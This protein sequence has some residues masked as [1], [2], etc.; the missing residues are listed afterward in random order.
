M[1]TRIGLFDETD[2]CRGRQP[3]EE[4]NLRTP[5][6]ERLL[7]KRVSENLEEIGNLQR[8][9]CENFAVSWIKRSYQMVRLSRGC[10]HDIRPGPRATRLSGLQGKR[11][12]EPAHQVSS[13]QNLT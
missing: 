12:D 1:R 4:L 11:E 13:F 10:N 9:L 8:M 5:I 6:D 2:I 7:V 3:P